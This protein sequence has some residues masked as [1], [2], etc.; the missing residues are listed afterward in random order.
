MG[1]NQLLLK[2]DALSSKRDVILNG[3]MKNDMN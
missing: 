1:D 3:I 2:V